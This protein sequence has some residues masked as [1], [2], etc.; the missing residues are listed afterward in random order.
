MGIA[1]DLII[2]AIVLATIITGYV[3]GLAKSVLKLVSFILAI[4][5][6]AIIYKPIGNAI[7]DN[8]D[9]DENI[10]TSLV[11]SLYK[12]ESKDNSEKVEEVKEEKDENFANQITESLSNTIKE[13]TK[14]GI[15]QVAEDTS[16]TI[17]YVITAIGLFIIVNF[18][19]I[20]VT[21]IIGAITELPIIKQVDKIGGIAFGAI[22]GVLFIYI[23]LAFI[24]L[25]SFV[26][27]DN[28]VVKA[29]AESCI[30]NFIYNNNFIIN[31][32]FSK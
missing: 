28:A 21:L 7:I 17:V 20:I 4:I 24:S 23:V 27:A 11:Q 25:S 10:K 13:N 22:E 29:V 31:I 9:I 8:T 5:I 2:V 30:G 3:K 32:F 26:W 14:E 1:V 6:V 18:V 19:L 16:K 15:T 12:E